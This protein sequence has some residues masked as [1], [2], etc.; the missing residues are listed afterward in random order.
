M[1]FTRF[2]SDFIRHPRQTGTLVESS[3]FLAKKMVKEMNGTLNVVEF[4]PGTGAVTMEILKRLPKNGKLTCFEI[5]S[6]FCKTLE[7]I[8]DPRLK[9]IND[10]AQNCEKYVDELDCI[11][12]GLPL[13]LFTKPKREKIISLSSKSK[14]YIQF[15]YTPFL[16]KKMKHY[17]QHVKVKFVPLNFPPAFIYVCTSLEK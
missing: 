14:L 17:F 6:D 15:Q 2:I 3:K 5:N 16:R 4:G 10:D 7:S 8:E 9:V 12:S 13:T 1:Q 11:I